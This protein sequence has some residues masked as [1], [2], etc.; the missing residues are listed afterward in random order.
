MVIVFPNIISIYIVVNAKIGLDMVRLAFHRK[1]MCAMCDAT[2]RRRSS[3]TDTSLKLYALAKCQVFLIMYMFMCV[4]IYA[5]KIAIY[6][7]HRTDTNAYIH[8]HTH[9][10][11]IT[12]KI[13][14][15]TFRI[16]FSQMNFCHTAAFAII[17]ISGV[18]ERRNFVY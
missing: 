11:D 9:Q 10:H 1:N 17:C 5:S 18:V 12:D 8:T 4:C 16:D 2:Q 3:R 15:Q 14:M 7:T 6:C 13:F